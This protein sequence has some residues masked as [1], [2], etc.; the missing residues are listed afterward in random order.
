MR[1]IVFLA[2]QNIPAKN[3]GDLPMKLRENIPDIRNSDR[4]LF[5]YCR[6]LSVRGDNLPP[7]SELPDADRAT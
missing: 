5:Q 1:H 7:P 3:Y 2:F 6:K 4:T